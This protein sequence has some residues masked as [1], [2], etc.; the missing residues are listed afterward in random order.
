MY[1]CVKRVCACRKTWG[2]WLAASACGTQILSA[3]SQPATRVH[4]LVCP[5]IASHLDLNSVSQANICCTSA[6]VHTCR[7]G[8]FNSSTEAVHIAAKLYV[9]AQA[10]LLHYLTAPHA[11]RYI[12]RCTPALWG[13]LQAARVKS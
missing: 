13:R 7:G 5:H 1:G 6:G 9:R 2:R 11:V 10:V 12:Q 3:N 8:L 4:V